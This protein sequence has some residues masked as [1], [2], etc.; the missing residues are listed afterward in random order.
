M[1]AFSLLLA[2][3]MVFLSDASSL[4][5]RRCKEGPSVSGVTTCPSRKEFFKDVN[6]D[7]DADDA[8]RISKILDQPILRFNF[9][10]TF[11][12]I[13]GFGFTLTGGSAY[14]LMGM[15]AENRTAL[16][17]ELFGDLNINT[18]RL[19]IG[20]SDLDVGPFSYDDLPDNV[21]EDLGLQYFS[22][23]RD[24]QYCIPVLKEILKIQPNLQL[25]A[26]PWS[27]PSWMKDNQSTVGGSLLPKYYQ[28]Y[29]KYLVKYLQEMA[30]EGLPIHTVTIQNEPLNDH[31]NPSMVM[32][33]SEQ[34][35]FIRDFLVPTMVDARIATW[36]ETTFK[37]ATKIVLYDHNAD[38]IDYPLD[39]LGDKTVKPFVEGSA[40]HMYGGDISALSQVH[41]AHP[42][43]NI[44]FTEQWVSS[45]GDFEGDLLW[46]ACNVLI[47]GLRNFAQTVL[48]WN[49]SSNSQ[50]T[51]YTEGGCSKCLGAVTIDGSSVQ[52]NTAYYIVAHASRFLLPGSIR[53]ASYW[54][55]NTSG[56]D[57]ESIDHVVFTT[58]DDNVVLLL[59]NR[60]Y[61]DM[62]IGIPRR[63]GELQVTLRA[64]S[65]TT[66][67]LEKAIG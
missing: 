22:M 38:R 30:A 23:Y 43:K 27:A 36:D 53:V 57:M 44:H 52:R 7:A 42:D 18:L 28:T 63:A 5:R 10:Q 24:Q 60:G 65:L 12:S 39:I 19:S 45:E 41:E 47:G 50:L 58:P 62:V 37:S 56:T 25:W 61:D 21:T 48:E 20:S 55:N 67:F 9:S 6:I 40:F 4:L 11:Q 29:A 34:G 31:N 1:L 14:H 54:D 66:F 15:S 3:F 32:T 16:L 59:S 33:A 51:P 8:V 17:E 2:L 35:T 64:R 46:H 13:Q 49:L 26:S